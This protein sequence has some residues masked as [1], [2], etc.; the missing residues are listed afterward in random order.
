MTF[1]LLRFF[2]RW[3]FLCLCGALPCWLAGGETAARRFE[4]PAGAAAETLKRFGQQAGREILF[5]AEVVAGIT[6]PE[7]RGEW[8]PLVALE[9]LL[10]ATGLAF[11]E[12]PP[13]GA[14]LI[15]RAKS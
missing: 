7:L 1:G 8:T 9:R 13:S 2:R 10:A 11:A 15:F 4:V 14:L 12:D 3:A 6:T 5:P